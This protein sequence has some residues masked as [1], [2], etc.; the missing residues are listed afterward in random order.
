MHRTSQLLLLLAQK[1]R[2]SALPEKLILRRAVTIAPHRDAKIGLLQD[3][4]GMWQ[5]AV[6]ADGVWN[7]IK[8]VVEIFVVA[9]ARAGKL[10]AA[11]NFV[12]AWH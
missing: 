2:V 7:A 3:V 4:G 1:R 11:G 5:F 12:N 8:P 9:D 10:G 6:V